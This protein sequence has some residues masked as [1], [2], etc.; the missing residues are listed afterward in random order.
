MTFKYTWCTSFLGYW[1]CFWLPPGG[2]KS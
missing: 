1:L 2:C